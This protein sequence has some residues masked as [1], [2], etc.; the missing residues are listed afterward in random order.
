MIAWIL[1]L[2]INSFDSEWFTTGS[3]SETTGG[4]WFRSFRMGFSL[5]SDQREKSE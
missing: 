1:L 3:T 4:K 2:W 5:S